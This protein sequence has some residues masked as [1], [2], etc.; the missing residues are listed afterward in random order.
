MKRQEARKL[1][2]LAGALA[3]L[4]AV[5]PGGAQGPEEVRTAFLQWAKESLHPVSNADLDASTK[6]LA[7][8]ERMIGDARVVGLSEGIHA[9]TEPLIFRNR[10]SS[11]WLGTWA[12]MQSLS[13]P[14]SSRVGC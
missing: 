3:F 13:N 6:D 11:T 4:T 2:V 10:C 8:L 9:A 5:A 7:P 1:T 14:A 12:S